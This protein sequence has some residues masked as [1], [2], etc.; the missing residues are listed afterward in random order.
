MKLKAAILFSIISLNITVNA[1]PLKSCN[2]PKESLKELDE[3]FSVVFSE[4]IKEK[5]QK[6]YK[7]KRGV[8]SS[9]EEFK[10]KVQN[11]EFVTIPEFKKQAYIHEDHHNIYF[12]FYACS[13]TKSEQKDFWSKIGDYFNYSIGSDED[14][15]TSSNFS[16]QTIGD[17]STYREDGLN[18]TD[19]HSGLKTIVNKGKSVKRIGDAAYIVEYKGRKFMIDLNFPIGIN[20]LVSTK[21]NEKTG[22]IDTYQYEGF[23]YHSPASY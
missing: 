2:Q 15:C 1:E 14:K 9:F 16:R 3:P 17:Y 7:V 12:Q 10:Q 6:K 20:P 5:L 8:V 21:Y 23:Y 18:N 19:V 22:D 4:E 13:R 11:G